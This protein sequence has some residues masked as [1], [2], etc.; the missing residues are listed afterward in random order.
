ML[1]TV[2]A[3]IH[4][5][6]TTVFSMVYYD[7]LARLVPPLSRRKVAKNFL[8]SAKMACFLAIFAENSKFF[9]A[10]RRPCG[11]TRRAKGTYQT[12]KKS[13]EC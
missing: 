8:F 2:I 7:L 10:L 3:I 11:G 12:I 9:A 5:T 4:R 6:V 1:H 13:S